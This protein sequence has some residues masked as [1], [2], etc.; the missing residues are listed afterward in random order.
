MNTG[1]ITTKPWLSQGRRPNAE[2]ITFQRWLKERGEAPIEKIFDVTAKTQGAVKS[3]SPAK[4][5]V[6]RPRSPVTPL[7]KTRVYPADW[8]DYRIAGINFT[9]PG[10]S[11]I[12][13][14]SAGFRTYIT[15]IVLLVDG[16]TAIT[17]NFGTFGSSGPIPLGDIDQPRGFVAPHALAGGP[18]G[19]G[20]FS[21]YSSG[22]DTLVAGYVQYYKEEDKP[23]S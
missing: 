4:D 6:K 18:C 12:V 9:G 8:K 1:V 15:M 11:T 10:V 21:I 5:K 23:P 2:E 3:K 19:Q 13:G 16:P 22:E 14:A 17:L 20:N 7:P